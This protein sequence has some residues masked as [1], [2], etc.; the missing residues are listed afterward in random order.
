MARAG[1]YGE[2]IGATLGAASWV[3]ELRTCWDVCKDM[4]MVVC[5]WRCG[6]RFD[7][8]IIDEKMEGA[9]EW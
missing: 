4:W 6:C 5:G 2:A 7:M 3:E 1:W 8:L 9:L